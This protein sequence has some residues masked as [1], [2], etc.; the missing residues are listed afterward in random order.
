MESPLTE[1]T[2][3]VAIIVFAGALVFCT[4]GFGIG[5]TSIP[6][7]LLVVDEQT[8]VVLVNSVSLP[9]FGL[10]IW[11]T[12]REIPARR[13]LPMSLAGLAGVPVGVM[14]LSAADTALLRIAIVALIIGL[15]LLAA[16]DRRWALPQS[17]WAELGTGF[18]VS[19]LL[20]AFGVG[21]ALMALTLLSQ[22]LGRQALRG[23][24][25]LYFLVVEGA[26]V[27]G[28][29]FAGLLT[30]ERLALI[31]AATLP[32][33]LAFGA[34]ALILRRMNEAVF[35]KAVIATIMATSGIVL[36]REVVSLQWI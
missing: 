6:M 21:G 5:V 35:R 3:I 32:V 33:L 10:V 13:A 9:M 34:A 27:I 14:F 8:A 17:R 26:G 19:A 31:G 15:T 30:A 4:V 24:L 28:Y 23:S 25:S 16:L 12:R 36:V 29:G 20:N 2:L 18:A 7:L 11:H 22:Q 1:Q